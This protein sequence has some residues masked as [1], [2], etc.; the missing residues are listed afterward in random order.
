[1]TTFNRVQGDTGDT[2]TPWLYGVATFAGAT[3]VAHVWQTGVTATNLTAAVVDGTD[4]NGNPCG[5]CTVHLASWITTATPGDW[6]IEEQVTFT[7]TT[8]IT[9]PGGDSPDVLHIRAQGA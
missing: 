1:M 3:V 8:I 7:D 2:I 4:D 5:V 9:W 6:F